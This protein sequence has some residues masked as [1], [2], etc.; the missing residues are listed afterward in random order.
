MNDTDLDI[1]EPSNWDRSY[2]EW[3]HKGYLH[4]PGSEKIAS[5][6]ALTYLSAC[7]RT[8]K[9]K[10]IL[11]LGAGIGTMTD[12]IL[13]HPFRP[14]TFWTVEQN[15]FC[16]NALKVNL[17]HHNPDRYTVLTTLKEL[18]AAD[19]GGNV[20]LYVGDGG[21]YVPEEMRGA[22]SGT[23]FFAEGDRRKLRAMFTESLPEDWHVQW[24]EYG[25]TYRWRLIHWHRV[26]WLNKYLPYKHLPFPGKVRVKGCGI[27]QVSRR[28]R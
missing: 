26:D 9:P 19:I 24:R 21:F 28:K 17:A 6:P 1:V 3:V 14:S 27:G 15:D 10:S 18:A 7:L 12:F 20:D 25:V 11:E 23:V 16:Q 5:I 22:H 4:K 13:T 2:A 8:F